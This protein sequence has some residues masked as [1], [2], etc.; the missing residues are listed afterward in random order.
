M[1]ATLEQPTYERSRLSNTNKH[2]AIPAKVIVLDSDKVT[3]E[4]VIK[5]LHKVIPGM[6]IPEA[7]RH[8]LK[9][10][11]EGSSVVWEGDIELAEAYAYQ[12]K[13]EG[14]VVTVEH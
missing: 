4:T 8:A 14:M 5:G 13:K 6:T 2:G 3:F 11:T 12:L 10:H 9:V 7:E 1:F